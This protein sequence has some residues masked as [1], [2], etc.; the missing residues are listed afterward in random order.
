MTHY[1]RFCASAGVMT[2]GSFIYQYRRDLI[3][4]GKIEPFSNVLV[5]AA[6]RVPIHPANLYNRSCHGWRTI[7]RPAD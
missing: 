5:T 4:F 2:P 6:H 3:T 1:V 7:L